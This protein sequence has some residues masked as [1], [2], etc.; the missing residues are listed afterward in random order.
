MNEKALEYSYSLFSQDGYN[1]SIED[2]KNL[3][4]T[5][6]DALNYSYSL[7][8]SDGY[9]GSQDDF[10]NLISLP[11]PIN[12]EDKDKEIILQPEIAEVPEEIIE[13]N[14]RWDK[15]EF[16]M[17]EK[18]A[19][20]EYS[21]PENK[22]KRK[23]LEANEI[24]SNLETSL[25]NIPEEKITE[26]TA[27][28]YFKLDQRPVSI[29]TDPN[30]EPD[31][32]ENLTFK[33]YRE[34]GLKEG[35][36]T[37]EEARF[38][39]GSGNKR[40]GKKYQ[41]ID[42]YLS[43]EKLQEYNN[44][45]QTGVLEALNANDEAEIRAAKNQ[46]LD[47]LYKKET[48]LFLRNVPKEVKDLMGPFGTDKKYKNVEDAIKSLDLG[49]EILIENNNKLTEDYNSYI[50]QAKPYQEGIN[51]IIGKINDIEKNIPSG[52][53][54]DGTDTQVKQYQILLAEVEKL[55][56]EYEQKGLNTIYDN[57]AKQQKLNELNLDKFN[58]ETRDVQTKA[59]IEK[60]LG[61]DYSLSARTGM[62]LE[63][64]FV[65]GLLNFGSLTSQLLLKGG[66]VLA[67]PANS[68][69]IDNITESI[70][71]TTRDY[72]SKL[73]EKRE[74]TIPDNIT[75]DDIENENVNFFD[76]FGESLANNSPSI[77]TTF[78]PGTAALRGASIVRGAATKKL[79]QQ[80]AKQAQ[81]RL[82]TAGTRTAQGIFFVGE[83]GG[84]YGD[85]ELQQGRALENLPKL[86]KQIE[87]ELDPAKKMQMQEDYED[88]ERISNYSFAQKAF[89]SYAYG[90]A[91]T[92]AETLGSLRIVNGAGKLAANIGKQEFKAGAYAS[93]LNFAANVTGKTISGIS[94]N[95]GKAIA[96]EEAEETLTQIA[97]NIIDIV[98][99]KE[100]KSIIEG[101]DKEFLANTAVTSFAIM[102][103]KT[104]GNT[105]N[106]LKNEFTTR[107][108]I[109][110]NQDDVVELIQLQEQFKAL[111]SGPERDALRERRRELLNKLAIED[112]RTLTKLNTL[113]N[114][115]IVEVADLARQMRQ[116]KNQMVK[117]GGTGDLSETGI[118]ARKQ[119][120]DQYNSI[121][122][123]REDLLNKRLKEDRSK[124]KDLREELGESF[125]NL[126]AEYYFGLYD[127]YKN[128]A[129]TLMPKNGKF[130]VVDTK[131]K[132]W[133]DDL[134]DLSEEELAEVENVINTG[135]NAAAVGNNI[136]INENVVEI[137]I[138]TSGVFTEG[139]YAAAAPIEELFHIQNKAKNIVDKDGMLSEEATK[140]VDQALEV[141]KNKFEL[142]KISEQDYNDLITRFNQY[143]TGGKGKVVLKSGE[144][145]KATADAE[146]IMA[147]MNNAVAIG[148]LKLEDI[149]TMPS[150]KDFI[151]GISKDIFGDSSW[152]FDLKTANDVF[153]FI[154]NYQSNIQ[155]GIKLALPDDE[156]EAFEKFSKTD[157][158]EENQTIKGIFDKFTGP[159]E[160][161]KFK[162]KEEF[163]KSPEYF[164]AL[165]E[166]E[167]SNTLDAS[168]R[169][170]VSQ[171]YLNMNPGFVKEVKERI[172]DKYQSEYDASKNSLF[173]WL[174]GKNK[175]GQTIIQLAA[176]DI[177]AK[178]SK[179]PTTV[180]TTKKVGGEDSK[181]TIAE[182]LVSD[183]ISPEEYTDMKLA[184]DKLNKIKPQQSK[185]ANKINLTNNEVNLAKREIVNFLR[186]TDRPDMT[187]PKK[188]FKALV[189]YTT[190]KGVQPGG[191]AKVIYDKLSLPKD[192][193]LSTKNKEAFIREIAEDLIALNKVDPAV[194]R[195]SKWT[196]FYELEIKNMNPTQMQKAIDEGRIPSTSNLKSGLDLFKTLDPS[197]DQ[198]VEYLNNIRPDVLKRKMPKFLGEVII[199]N[200]FNEIVDNP[201]QPVYDAKG[202]QTDNTIDLSESI[203]EEEVTRGAPQVRE[204]IARPKGIKFN[205]AIKEIINIRDLFQLEANGKDKLLKAYKLKDSLKIKN[206]DDI[207][208][209]IDML[210]S[211]IFKLGPKEMWFGPGKGTA[212]TSSS[213]N[214]GMSSKNP[215]WSKFQEEV[216]KLKND[217]TIKYG[218]KINGV[219]NED[220]WSLRNKYD[221]L[222]KSPETIEKNIKNGE[223]K[224]F[225]KQVA[226]IHKTLWKRINKEI[227]KDKNK[228]VGIATYLGITAND[229]GHWH[230][231][232]AQFE[233]YSKDIIGKR[234]EYEHAMPATAAYLYLLDATLSD[235]DFNAAYD[236]VI[237]NY[238]LI[239]LDKAM[240]DKL[241]NARTAK[242]YSLQRRMPD[243]WSVIDNFWWQRYFNDIVSSQDGG[244]DPNSIIGLNGKTFS[245]IFSVDASGNSTVVKLQELKKFSKSA[246][247]K[248][249]S[250]EV[251][252]FNKNIT[253][254]GII[255]YAKTVDEALNI[256]RDPNAAVK[257][258][259]VFDFDDTLATTKSDVLFT[260]PDGTE[261]RLNA[262]DFA[263][264]GAR[265]LEEGYTFDFTEFNKVTKGKPGPLLEVAKK[266]QAARGTEDVFVLTAR[267]PEAQ[268]AIKEF[269]DGVGLNIPLENITGLGNSTGEAKAKWMVEKAAEGYNDFYFA[270]DAYQ[271]VK[272]VKDAMSVLDV[273][274]KV[275]QAKIK[276]SKSV[277]EDFNK[278]I[279]QTTGIAS[280]KIYSEAKAKVRGAN[281][282]NKKF[283][284]PYSAEDFMGLIYPLL[285]KGKLGDSQMAWF[286]KNLLDPYARAQE[287]ISADRLQ[288]MED[289]KALKK[290][291]DVP[292]DLRKKTDSGFTKEQAVRVYLFNKA[293]FDVPGISKTDLNELLDLVN[294]DGVLKAFGDQI[295]NITKGDGYAKP[296][297]NWL[298]GTITTDLIDVLNTV[299]RAKY[300]EQSG[301][302]ANVELIFSKEN[303]N[304]LE[305]AYGT[306]Y[307][308]AMENILGRMKSGKNR[309]FSGNRLSNRVL[310][311]INNSTGAIMFF[312]TRSAVLQTISSINFLN[313]SFNNPIKAGAAFA[314][315]KQYWKDFVELIN[316]DYL[317]DRRNGL[318]LNIN[319]SEI[320]DAAATSKNKARAAINYILQKGFLPTQYADSFA[321][322]SGGATFYR[323]RINDLMENQGMSEADAKKQ[324]MLEWRE[325]AE[326]SQQ[327]SDP[328]KISAQQASDL[329]RVI[330]AFANTPMQYARI[331]KRALQDLIN[332]RG[333]AKTN[334][335]KIIYYAVVQNLIFNAL[336]SALFK[337]GFDE[338][339]DEKKE[340]MYLRTANGMLDSQL[341]GL[342]LAGATVA[343]IKNFLADIYERSGRSRPE[344]VDSV[345]EL[346][347]VSPPISSKISKIRQAAYQFDS[348]KRREEIFKK[349]FSIDNPAYEAFAKVISATV[350]IPLDRVYSKLDNISGAMS[351]DAETWQAIAMLAGWPKWNIM[352]DTKESSVFSRGNSKIRRRKIKRRTIKR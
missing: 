3:I 89:T 150:I 16:L 324:A 351:E 235:V 268:V 328:S 217:D 236:L 244:I 184:Q 117:L 80:A 293:G 149:E 257:K 106:M 121:N 27:K 158:Q 340:K 349:G 170:T 307:R 322:A 100:D 253:N 266:I 134:T 42:Q 18:E 153:N 17:E 192:G 210:K 93:P 171:A 35:F 252:K 83:G 281:K 213:K 186:K 216:Q 262:E 120:Q 313:W 165:L 47:N 288:L 175:A 139:A 273:K 11:D 277:N 254:E 339:E 208:V 58:D 127:F 178:K 64:F 32:Y 96:I 246:N 276:F 336:Q 1:G 233:G 51:N 180:T 305:A 67:N 232:G 132:N 318:K 68:A 71:Q 131:N 46:S 154:K 56:D 224:K 179:Q 173:G 36:L 15:G 137:N 201:K 113:S 205:K 341:R 88:L 28:N 265:L 91:A 335:S 183:E 115:E 9:N 102:A 323:N 133:R 259:R 33:E 255:G 297:E 62:A 138:A 286:K 78:V 76:W 242:G 270:D 129:M 230:K 346:L 126:N 65:G 34:K 169:N 141:I 99:L 333:D 314:N 86:K 188:F 69:I 272:A 109:L 320:A 237:N 125:V 90:S 101:I 289:F 107:Q 82:V 275:Q 177:Q 299:K 193:K 211:D 52:N 168:I 261:G 251:V 145:G 38:Y 21:K 220:I 128:V 295:F 31:F 206:E 327:S 142:G 10:F 25:K 55:Q 269:L 2:Y 204:K 95:A 160:N 256:A 140:A 45:Q 196:P 162:S 200:E 302:T 14:K 5:N 345:Y 108:E 98:A 182:T 123:R 48:Q 22:E 202:N 114:E 43:P 159:A 81:E 44:Y 199:K 219:K 240:D 84:R 152:M 203:T 331:Q 315:Q 284:I 190:G 49:R 7:F 250:N 63:E 303:L 212:F 243:D 104:M 350:N 329:G 260:S 163:K 174:T 147:Q 304:K 296:G 19:F 280:E 312:N 234:Y 214:L 347:R 13:R 23:K 249:L 151:N 248:D 326:I 241:R 317:V 26:E 207:K 85:L 195:R 321:I 194:M 92:L 291:L 278:I 77:I 338:E 271:N 319:E 167:Q 316:S 112:V 29:V 143:K 308:E 290:A 50:E 66:K 54:E 198:V 306:K 57:L 301:Y 352:S 245:E 53:I 185:I 226:A 221:K 176:G 124:I 298:V 40:V 155:K 94:K 310:D 105:R 97:H 258:I 118:K 164:E 87:E 209:Y 161:R 39:I 6:E 70:V 130:I 4:S 135:N 72:N 334:V 12:T 74:T 197:V 144:R 223:I 156:D 60:Q 283:F 110:N 148:A 103:P 311:Y 274:S 122:K 166:I 75:L 187:D 294:S 218:E 300:L 239:A 231:L 292:K 37:E 227:S 116:L 30:V 225:N 222:F 228:A 282:G 344:Y 119:I 229:T 191:F 343:V 136:I 146:E 342:G 287:N 61:L 263:R 189:D 330:L 279:E 41:P 172:S 309:L 215:L 24:F 267:A 337:L 111:E 59:I 325:T 157:Q 20:E 332:G 73:A 238:K 79:S 264:D 348:K 8:S 181:T 247:I 285:S